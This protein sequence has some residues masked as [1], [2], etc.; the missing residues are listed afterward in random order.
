MH[1][2][3][4]V[5]CVAAPPKRPSARRLERPNGGTGLEFDASVD[6]LRAVAAALGVKRS[7]RA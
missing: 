7:V 2:S 5:S 4:E 1:A 3:S 6:A